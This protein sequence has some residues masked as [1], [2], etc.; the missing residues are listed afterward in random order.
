MM[1]KSEEHSG[2]RTDFGIEL[3]YKFQLCSPMS[4]L[5]PESVSPYE[6]GDNVYLLRWAGVL[7]GSYL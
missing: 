1:E 3:K 5:L 2:K 7:K 4:F 6:N